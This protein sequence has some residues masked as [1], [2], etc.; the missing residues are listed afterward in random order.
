M[1]VVI[2]KI[3]KML[4]MITVNF[5]DNQYNLPESKWCKFIAFSKQKLEFIFE[6]ALSVNYDW[7]FA[8]T[9]YGQSPSLKERDNDVKYK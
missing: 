5:I 9:T 1:I 8:S 7:P 2:L 4:I 3:A 6:W